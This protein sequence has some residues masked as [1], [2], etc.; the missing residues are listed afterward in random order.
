MSTRASGPWPSISVII[1]AFQAERFL[2]ES[3]DS[4]LA[5]DLVPLE[6]LVVDDGSTDA[7]AKI[8]DGFG[9]PVRLVR[10]E[11]NRGVSAAR[12][13]GVAEAVGE[14]IAQH[15]ADDRMRPHRLRVEAE[16]L[17]AGGTSAGCV[18]GLARSFSDDGRSLPPLAYGADGEPHIYGNSLV[19]AWRSTYER[20]G[21]YDESFPVAGDTDWLLRVRAAGLDVE[22]IPE[23]LTDRR[24][25]DTNLSLLTER[26]A[27][28]EVTRSLRRLIQERRAAE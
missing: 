28:R 25:H 23:E 24:W 7:T 17:V 19:L 11:V 16:H 5:Q 6:V 1:P 3:L 26:P 18:L 15:D 9:P 22:L 8:A 4:V 10:H 14:A 27:N 20:V 2:V 12:N 13:T 21:G